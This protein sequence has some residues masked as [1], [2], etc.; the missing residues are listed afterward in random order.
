MIVYINIDDNYI[1]YEYMFVYMFYSLGL[2]AG[3]CRA[4]VVDGQQVGLIR[5][6]VMKEI[7][8]HPQVSLVLLYYSL[9]ILL[10]YIF[11]F[12]FIVLSSFIKVFQVH[13]EYVQLNP[14]FRDYTERSARVDEILR[15]W[16]AG[17]KFV[18]LRGWREECHEVRAQF[19][20]LPLFKMD[21]SATCMYKRN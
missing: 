13:P 15:K 11:I 4:F 8:N 7:L 5:P 2:H 3:E 20:T 6:D 14:A 1:N 17:G 18:T 19:N 21:R 10:T 9:L 12:V 16:K